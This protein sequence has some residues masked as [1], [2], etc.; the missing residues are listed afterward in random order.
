MNLPYQKI[1][2]SYYDQLEALA[3]KRTHCVIVFLS[4][5]KEETAEGVITDL[6]SKEGAEFLQLDKGITIRLDHLVSVNGVPLNFV[7]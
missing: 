3:T 2:C 6:F 7:C 5:G 1:S 4:E